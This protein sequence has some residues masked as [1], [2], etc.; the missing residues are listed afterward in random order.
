MLAAAW[1]LP[2]FPLVLAGRF[3]GLPMVFMFV[4]LAAG[5]CYLAV[6]QLP[7]NWPAFRSH[8]QAP[9]P[10]IGRAHV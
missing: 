2:G 3:M 9:H 5:L 7:A 8:P 4:P 10:Q 6:R 1:L